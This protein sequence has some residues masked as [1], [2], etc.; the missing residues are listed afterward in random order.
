ML[1]EK[2]LEFIEKNGEMDDVVEV[3]IKPPQSGTSQAIDEI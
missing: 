2:V 3:N 1:F